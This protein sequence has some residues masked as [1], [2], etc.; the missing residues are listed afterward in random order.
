MYYA[1]L[2]NAHVFA[3]GNKQTEVLV[4]GTDFTAYAVYGSGKLESIVTVNMVMWNSTFEQKN[5]PYTALELP[6][7]WELAKVSRLTSPGAEIARDVTLA[8]QSVNEAGVIVGDRKVEK[9]MGRKV[10]VGAGEAVLVQ[11]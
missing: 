3:G 11:R 4:N 8:G 7:G 1:A 2:R 5:R 9:P 10:L 6:S